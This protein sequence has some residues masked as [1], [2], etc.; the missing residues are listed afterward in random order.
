M[1]HRHRNHIPAVLCHF[2]LRQTTIFDC[3]NFSDAA[4]YR[5]QS[6]MVVVRRFSS[7]TNCTLA[8]LSIR[9]SLPRLRAFDACRVF[10]NNFLH[11]YHRNVMF[12]NCQLP[13]MFKKVFFFIK[14]FF[15]LSFR[16]QSHWWWMKIFIEIPPN[17]IYIH[18]LFFWLMKKKHSDCFAAI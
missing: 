11:K 13:I 3:V 5:V 18:T 4:V 16:I 2:W 17:A 9:P 15:G 12:Y 7:F 8:F 14:C 10:P 6:N 1:K